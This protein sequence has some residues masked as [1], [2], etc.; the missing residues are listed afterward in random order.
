VNFELGLDA[1]DEAEELG[2]GG[3][4]EV[5]VEVD[6]VATKRTIHPKTKHQ[7]TWWHPFCHGKGREM[8]G[9][10]TYLPIASAR[11]LALW[12][13]SSEEFSVPM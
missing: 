5:H 13:V 7:P 8:T 12:R 6:V 1:S 3:D 9:L 2:D 4:D 10:K 11:S